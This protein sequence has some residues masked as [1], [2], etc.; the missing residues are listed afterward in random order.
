[1]YNNIFKVVET[2]M[3][4]TPERDEILS[5]IGDSERGVMKGFQLRKS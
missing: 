4:A 2:Q 5:F 1:M 3:S